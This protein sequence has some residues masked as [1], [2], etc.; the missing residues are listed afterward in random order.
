LKV[1]NI[2]SAYFDKLKKC[3]QE[4][5]YF[6]SRPCIY[7]QPDPYIHIEENVAEL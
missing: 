1:S 5:L 4:K 7:I 2:L 6:D 3:I